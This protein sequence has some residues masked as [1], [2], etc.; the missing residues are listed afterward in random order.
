[1]PE[2]QAQSKTPD[3]LS[4][5]VATKEAEIEALRPHEAGFRDRAMAAPPARGFEEA[6]ARHPRVRV[7]AEVKRRSPGAGDIRPGLDPAALAR[8]YADHGAAALSVLTDTPW[9]GGRLDDLVVAREAVDL[10]ALR[11]DFTLDRLQIDEARA[12]GADAILLIVRILGDGRLAD[13]HGY[14]LERG[15]AALVEV[16]DAEELDRAVAIGARI[17][18]INNRD[19]STFKTDLAV[20][21]A[22]LDRLPAGTVVVSESGIRNAADVER[23]GRAGVDAVLVGETI[24]RAADPGK[25]V[26]GL[27]AP[28][29]AHDVRSGR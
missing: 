12:A 15:M 4:R 7:I 26:A 14:A 3:I 24:L 23:L 9:F 1:L 28:A 18:G 19:L 5:I 29:R 10:P 22:L 27:A 2:T 11:K 25:M 13:L 21:E 8:A 20:T 17:V 16:H 6:L